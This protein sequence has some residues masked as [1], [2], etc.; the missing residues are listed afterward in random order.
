MVV[1]F[2]SSTASFA[3]VGYNTNKMDKNTG[4]LILVKNFGAL[5]GLD[6]LR[7]KD[8]VNY[9]K[10]ITAQNSRIKMP[11]FHV[12]ISA[13]GQSHTKQELAD[14]AVKWMD[15]MG[16]EKQP[17]LVVFHKDTDNNHVHIVSTRIDKQ[18]K[19]I[20][21]AFEHSRGIRNLNTITAKTDIEQALSYNFTTKAQ[22]KMILEAKEYVI[23]ENDGKM[24]FVRFGEVVDE[25]DQKTLDLRLA[26]IHQMH[27]KAASN[28]EDNARDSRIK[29]LTAIFHKYLKTL[30]TALAQES[31]GTYTSAFAEYLK[32]NFGVYLIFHAKNGLPPYGYTV[33]DH[34]GKYVFKGGDIMGL[35]HLLENSITV[36]DQQVSPVQTVHGQSGVDGEPLADHH[37]SHDL[38]ENQSDNLNDAQHHYNSDQSYTTDHSWSGEEATNHEQNDE[39]DPVEWIETSEIQHPAATIN[40]ADD[41]DDEAILGRNRR[42]QK[43]ART[44]TR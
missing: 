4:E 35:K 26:Q 7:P 1:R 14:V 9:L 23:I 42:R 32:Q 18:G 31:D 40:L 34:A 2:L 10:M 27:N 5:Q 24:Q 36:P 21:S 20:S 39:T 17:Y 8:Y 15:S 41:I 28:P 44:N 33:L 25:I 19:K 29:Q 13:K 43:K 11:Q 38:P 37:P 6:H 22:F 3:G 12:A 16:F 30:P